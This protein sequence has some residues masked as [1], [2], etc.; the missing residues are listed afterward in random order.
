M[1]GWRDG[2]FF[3]VHLHCHF[4]LE[5]IILDFVCDKSMCIS[6]R[7][8]V[9]S[10][11]RHT[12]FA[13]ILPIR[14]ALSFCCQPRENIVPFLSAVRV[15]RGSPVDHLFGRPPA[16]A[17]EVYPHPDMCTI[18]HENHAQCL[19]LIQKAME[20]KDLR[21]Q[22]VGPGPGAWACWGLGLG[23]Q[24]GKVVA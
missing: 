16:C 5:F 8:F 20:D 11:F 18:K 19:K 21:P 15:N 6:M 13:G 14:A 23:K 22:A 1:V 10:T 3:C 17:V 2:V 9:Q 12:F 7:T 24:G 4:P